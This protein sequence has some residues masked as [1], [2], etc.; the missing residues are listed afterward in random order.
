MRNTFKLTFLIISFLFA[1]PYGVDAREV[2][3]EPKTNY[4]N[5]ESMFNRDNIDRNEIIVT[6]NEKQGIEDLKRFFSNFGINNFK[7]LKTGEIVSI[8][9]PKNFNPIDLVKSIQSDK[10]VKLAEPNVIYE[11][12]SVPTD[13]G[14]SLQWHLAKINSPNAWKITKGSSNTIVAVIDGGVDTT[15]PEFN[16]VIYMPYN[17]VNGSTYVDKDEHGTHVAGIIGAQANG[18]GSVGVS[19]GVKIMPIDVF[20]GEYAST[21]DI[22]EGIY[23]AIK[24]GAKIINLSLGGDSYSASFQEAVNYASSKNVTIL[25][26]SGNDS[27]S[28]IAYPASY[29]KVLAIGATNRYDSRSSF[30]NY[31]NTLDF[32]APGESIYSTLPVRNNYYGYMSGTS[33]AT[34]VVSGIVSLMLSRNPYLSDEQVLEI[35]KKATVDLGIAG[36]DKYYGYGRV[37]AAKALALVSEPFK[38]I[39]S[40]YSFTTVGDNSLP[41]SVNVLYGANIT[42]DVYNSSGIHVKNIVRNKVVSAGVSTIRWNGTNANGS[43]VGTGIYTIKAKAN[44]NGKTFYKSSK[45]SLNNAVAPNIVPSQTSYYYSKKSKASL[46][47]YVKLNKSQKV[48]ATIYN[49]AGKVIKKLLTNYA[50]PSGNNSIRWSGTDSLGRKVPDGTYRIAVVGKDNKNRVSKK[51]YIYVYLDSVTPVVSKH[52]INSYNFEVNNANKLLG[53]FYITEKAYVNVKILNSDKKVVRTLINNKPFSKGIINYTWD[54]LYSSGYDI[55]N[56]NHYVSITVIDYAK[57]SVSTLSKAV[58][59]IDNRPPLIQLSSNSFVLSSKLTPLSINYNLTKNS[60][61][62]VIIQKDGITVK[63]LIDNI[64]Q[65]KGLNNV[66][67][68][69][70]DDS[71][72]YVIDGKYQI[73]FTTKDILDRSQVT[74]GIVNVSI[75]EFIIE[76][77]DVVQSFPSDESNVAEVF[78]NIKG[79]MQSATVEVVDEFNGNIVTLQNIEG[80]NGSYYFK[81]DGFNANGVKVSS[82]IESFTFKIN[83][84]STTGKKASKVINVQNEALP[85]E[86]INISY[87]YNLSEHYLISGIIVDAEAVSPLDLNVIVFD[88]DGNFIDERNFGKFNGSQE[89][90]YEKPASSLEYLCV[91][92]IELIDKF[93]NKFYLQIFE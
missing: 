31:G 2:P 38:S 11:S 60:S 19:T 48:T 15:H 51:K 47:T 25:A 67:W 10:I 91:Y 29:S 17:A 81:W 65:L 82:Q 61:V 42:V 33:M 52:S 20:S 1:A 16:G 7:E 21:S 39:S 56:G 28:Y 27:S 41:I 63:K 34:P 55:S 84:I 57:N 50:L 85:S 8:D 77:P 49:S 68:D 76:G 93:G 75:E 88:Y 92:Y 58:S 5:V 36:W 37:D 3:L 90:I 79:T 74:I 18:K 32:T 46:R 73:V 26:A 86:L 70:R 23:Y 45:V 83:A 69:G 9:V 71:N 22:V 89:F 30:S 80:S 66:V 87:D 6:F 12:L 72:N 40:R 14:Y 4:M 62:S 64:E 54:G 59:V 78:F 24:N 13:D 53:S 43:Y 44:L 35:L